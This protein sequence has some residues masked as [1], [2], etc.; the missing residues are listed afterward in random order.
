MLPCRF[1]TLKITHLKLAPGRL[2]GMK[3]YLLEQG[4]EQIFSFT[5]MSLTIEPDYQ[6]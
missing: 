5:S 2:P 3:V 4:R 1:I 6:I